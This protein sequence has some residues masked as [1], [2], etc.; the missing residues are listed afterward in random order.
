MRTRVLG[1]SGA[2]QEGREPG[3][4]GPGAGAAPA[5]LALPA[6]M[7]RKAAWWPLSCV[8]HVI[9]ASLGRP[10]R[11]VVSGPRR[12]QQPAV[13]R[14]DVWAAF[15]TSLKG[16]F[17]SKFWARKILDMIRRRGG[18]RNYRWVSSASNEGP[19]GRKGQTGESRPRGG[20]EGAHLPREGCPGRRGPFPG[21]PAAGLTNFPSTS[22]KSLAISQDS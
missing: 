9:R 16:T 8:R 21:A 14:G 20:A 6:E 4:S 13:K 10:H 19:R 2:G 22:F 17:F 7:G 1:V 15:L 3:G 11:G 18:A 5:T 12:S